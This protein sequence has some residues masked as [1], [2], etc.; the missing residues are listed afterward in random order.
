MEI[1]T[2][3][4]SEQQTDET[5]LTVKSLLPGTLTNTPWIEWRC[6]RTS[7]LQERK[8]KALLDQETSMRSKSSKTKTFLVQ[9]LF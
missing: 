4:I 7:F 9:S 5:R 2:F 8:I 6:K 1:V 3:D